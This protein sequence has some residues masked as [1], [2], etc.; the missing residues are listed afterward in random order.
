MDDWDDNVELPHAP[1]VSSRST[2]T[3]AVKNKLPAGATAALKHKKPAGVK[4]HVT[5]RETRVTANKNKRA[6]VKAKQAAKAKL[7]KKECQVEPW[8]VGVAN[9]RGS[10]L[11]AQSKPLVQ[12][13]F[14]RCHPDRF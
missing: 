14:A 9:T 8:L 11:L 13:H 1:Q 6:T 2:T 3:A 7:A 10:I 12:A 4:K 5:K